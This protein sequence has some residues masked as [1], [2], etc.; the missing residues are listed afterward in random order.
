M[1][2]ISSTEENRKKMKRNTQYKKSY[3]KKESKKQK[4]KSPYSNMDVL[5]EDLDR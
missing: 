3:A 1:K 4:S 5:N 2:I